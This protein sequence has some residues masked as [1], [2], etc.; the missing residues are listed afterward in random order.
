MNFLPTKPF[1]A[2]S[3]Q[4]EDE[5]LPGVKWGRAEWVPSPAYWSALAG[6]N[7]DQALFRKPDSLV[8][9]ISF[10]LLGGYGI[11]AELNCAAFQHLKLH[12]VFDG[13]TTWTSGKIESLLRDQLVNGPSK[14]RY[15]FPRQRA[16]RLSI[17]LTRLNAE[18]FDDL[19]ALCLR[20]HMLSFNGIGPKTASWIARNWTGSDEVAIIDIHVHRAGIRMG[21]FEPTN[22]LPQDYFRMEQRFLQF[23]ERIAVRASILDM[24]IW[25]TMRKLGK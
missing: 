3:Y 22:S 13:T 24:L 6:H 12:G 7:L 5:I 14:A 25:S 21:L 18:R 11:T 4:P 2:Y 23:A 16:E 9:E 19:P 20:D 1:L 15:R 10:C 17:A 8:E